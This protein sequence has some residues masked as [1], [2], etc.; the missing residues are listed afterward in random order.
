M[1]FTFENDSHGHSFMVAHDAIVGL[2]NSQGMYSRLLA[3]MM[4]TEWLP[5]Y[6][7]TKEVYF[8]DAVEFVLYIEC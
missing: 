1:I 8:G 5:L 2:A 3:H 6:D 4:E 7:L